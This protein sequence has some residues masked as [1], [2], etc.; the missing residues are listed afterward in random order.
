MS[1]KK[2]G[3]KKGG[4]EEKIP[5]LGRP[6]NNV[7]IGIV[8]LPN[9]GK[10]SLFNLMCDV[11]V[12]A[13][14]FPY[15]TIEPTDAMVP[16]PDKRFDHLVT[17]F[18]PKKEIPAV[19]QVTDIA[20]LMKGASTGEGL[21]NNFLSNI[22]AVDAI[23]HVTRAFKD[24]DIEHVIGEVD[25]CRDFE[26]IR[27]ELV[28]KDLEWVTNRKEAMQKKIRNK[29]NKEI[30]ADIATA[31]KVMAL[32]EAGTEVRMHRWAPKE[33]VF[34]NTMQL[35]TSKPV[36]YLVNISTKNFETQKNKWLK[37]IKEW[38][39]KNSPGDQVI[40]FSV[41][42]EQKLAEMKSDEDRKAFCEEKKLMSMLPRIV[43]TGYKALRLIN[44]FTVGPDEV[45]AWSIREGLKAPG[46]AGVIHGDFEKGFIK[47][48]VYNYDD[49]K[50]HGS[51][52]EVAAKGLRRS[53]G[54]QYVMKNGDIVLFKANGA[55]AR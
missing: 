11:S 40:P 45:R 55:K 3:K 42:F 18:K 23:Y 52:K 28:L 38:V 49:F 44:F 21:G 43:Q 27:H 32:L 7:K 15:C 31:E 39:K 2:K 36:V 48:E 33:I 19:L 4:E 14:N 24:K 17:E 51:E 16:L 47:A 26:V 13:S 53:Q 10:S 30:E 9:V 20:G 25:P 37:A 46:A 29:S 1:G 5:L 8:G 41:T 35:L 22:Q 54:K 50:E 6:T 34:L 12:P